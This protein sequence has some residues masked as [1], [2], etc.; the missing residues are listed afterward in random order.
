MM[1]TRST[2]EIHHRFHGMSVHDHQR[3]NDHQLI[4]LLMRLRPLLLLVRRLVPVPPLRG[5][6]KRP[7]LATLSQRQT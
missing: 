3:L 4:E 6:I 1:S 7:L 5:L 2:E